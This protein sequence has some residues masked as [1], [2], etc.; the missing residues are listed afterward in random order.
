MPDVSPP[1]VQVWVNYPG[2]SPEQVE[3]DLAKPIESAANTVA[4]VKRI[5]SRSEEGRSLTWV[6]FRYEVDMDRAMQEVRDKLAQIRASFPRDAKDPVVRRAGGENDQPVASFALL[7]KDR[8]PRELT[9]LAEQVVQKGFER[10][11]GVGRVDLGGNVTRQ[12]QVRVDAAKLTAF[13]L[14]VDQVVQALRTANVSVPV[15]AIHNDTSRIDHPGRRQAAI[16]HA[17]RAHHRRP[18][19][20]RADPAVTGGHGRRCANANAQSLSRVNGQHGDRVSGLQGAGRQHRRSRSRAQVRGRDDPQAAPA[21]HGA[22]VH[23]GDG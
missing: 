13:G 20:R 17:V 23:V 18:Q 9:L 14:S 21:G 1:G 10:V 7:G 15:G 22:Q 8:T 2:A 4:G 11:K 6:E 16:A 19:R 3:N 12:V 5:L